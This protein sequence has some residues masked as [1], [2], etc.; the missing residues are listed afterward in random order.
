MNSRIASALSALPVKMLWLLLLL[1]SVA[2][3]A[4]QQSTCNLTAANL[5]QPLRVVSI[6]DAQTLSSAAA[7]PSVN[8]SA[9]WD[10]SVAL[11]DMITV[12]AGTQLTITGSSVN[13][14]IDGMHSTQLFNVLQGSTLILETLLLTRGASSTEGGAITAAAGS[15]VVLTACTLTE[16]TATQT[17]GAIYSAGVLQIE[18]CVMYNNTAGVSAG[19]IVVEVNSTVHLSNTVVASNIATS[20]HAGAI[21]VRGKL[22]VDSCMFDSNAASTSFGKGGAIGA[23]DFT[24]NIAVINSTF[25]KC[26]AYMG[27]AISCHGSFAA[28]AVSTDLQG[29]VTATD[30]QFI[31]K[32]VPWTLMHM[33]YQLLLTFYYSA[34]DTT[35][36]T[37]NT[38]NSGG[39]CGAFGN[40]DFINCDFRDNVATASGGALWAG[41]YIK[42]APHPNVTVT[43]SA[44]SNN[45]ANLGGAVYSKSILNMQE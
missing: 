8:V 41:R 33:H 15:R 38:A 4:Q 5:P 12:G 22:T 26:G 37:G 31:G 13:A 23:E 6:R 10:G 24:A 35:P 16:N 25:T 19:A 1:L 34:V 43:R 32:N 40:F 44:F 27:G 9:V 18:Q 20:S 2:H 45:S 28:G 11:A 7:C 42:S 17:A 36:L 3:S 21:L 29:H 39:A 30:C 14:T